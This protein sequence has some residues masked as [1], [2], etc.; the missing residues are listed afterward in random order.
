MAR[1]PV[2]AGVCADPGQWPFASYRAP[3]GLVPKAAWLVADEVLSLFGRT[4]ERARAEF[5]R[6]VRSGHLP[7]SDDEW[8]LFVLRP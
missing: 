4:P 7:A 6:L 2:A 3:R 8:E 5:A 1:N